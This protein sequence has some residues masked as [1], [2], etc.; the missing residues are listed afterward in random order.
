MV[1]YDYTT[2]GGE[3]TI[4][5]A[6]NIESGESVVIPDNL[7]GYP[8]VS[9]GYRAF[10]DQYK[11]S[12]CV[13]PDSIRIIEESAFQG[14]SG[15]TVINLGNSITSIGYNA[16]YNCGFSSITI[17]AGVTSLEGNTFNHCLNLTS[18][19][20]LGNITDLGVGTFM[21]CYALESFIIPNGVTVLN[22]TFDECE[23]L[24]SVTIPEGVTRFKS[25]VFYNCKKLAS[26]TLPSSLTYIGSD[27]FYNCTLLTEI[28]IPNNVVEIAEY[29]FEGCSALM[30]INFLENTIPVVGS[31]W[32]SGV[33]IGVL[34]HAHATSDFPSPGNIF[35]DGQPQGD[36]GILMGDNLSPPPVSSHPY[37]FRLILY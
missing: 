14:C 12:S 32:L 9:I 25:T 33:P 27:T 31:W 22:D 35:P 26:I 8:V 13:L 23:N 29:A 20:F 16:F 6:Y 2:S 18:V 17:P 24:T 10:R 36:S 7:D 1:S 11:M 19:T 4:T 34:G 21:Q 5:K 3:A 37:S 15:M 30:N 28:T